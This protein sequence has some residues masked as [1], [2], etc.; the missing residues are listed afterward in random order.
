LLAAIVCGVALLAAG[1]GSSH[2]GKQL[3]SSSVAQ[4]KASLDSI[5]RRFTQ[6]DG[7]CQDITEGNDTDVSAVR[8]KIDNLPSNVDK[9]VRDALQESF[10]NLFQLVK[11]ECNNTQT[12]TNTTPS[13]TTPTPTETVPTQTETTPTETTPTQPNTTPTT[14][15]KQ[16]KDKKG[17]D[18]NGGSAAP[19]GE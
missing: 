1:C 15:G 9:D 17:G 16:K 11:D 4:L 19:G 7:A 13:E 6:G 3:P 14:P 18:G 2:K 12:E 5:Q 8:T 10:N